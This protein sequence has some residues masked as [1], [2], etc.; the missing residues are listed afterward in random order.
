MTNTISQEFGEVIILEK[1]SIWALPQFIDNA[2]VCKGLLNRLDSF[3]KFQ[4]SILGKDVIESK[5]IPYEELDIRDAFIS[6]A[7]EDREKIALP[8]AEALKD[9]GLSIWFDEHE[10][11]LG[12]SLRAKIEEGLKISRFGVTILS[13]HFFKKRWPQMELDGLL[14]LEKGT[15]KI[16]PIWHELSEEN[17]REYS[18][19]LAGRLGIPTSKGIDAVA[20]A[21]LKAVKAKK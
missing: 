8:I 5:Q 20:E 14:A 1:G 11:T 6:Y 3:I 16:L 21:I 18:P 19:I 2:K 15:K 4:S 17:V 12:D 13:H 7:S 10:L 9:K